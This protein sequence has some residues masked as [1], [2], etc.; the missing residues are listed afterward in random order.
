[1]LMVDAMTIDLKKDPV[2]GEYIEAI[3][4]R[5]STFLQG[6]LNICNTKS[7]PYPVRMHITIRILRV[8]PSEF[9]ISTQVQI[10]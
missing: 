9:P 5:V 8:R 2:Q 3:R 10:P 1:M 6:V 7:T 4:E